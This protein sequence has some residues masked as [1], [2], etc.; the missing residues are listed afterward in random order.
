[1]IYISVLLKVL[2]L[3]LLSFTTNV[4][5]GYSP[6][7]VSCPSNKTLV[8]QG[9]GLSHDEK[10]WLAK[11]HSITTP[12]LKAFLQ[13]KTNLTAAEINGVFQNNSSDINVG[14][15][16]SG[17]GYRA[18]LTGAGELSAL[19]N[20]TV[21]AFEHGLGGLLESTTYISGLSGGNWLTGSLS[22][23]DWISVQ[24]IIDNKYDIW[25]LEN[26]IFLP[27]G[28]HP[29]KTYEVFRNI[30]LDVEAKK[31]AG[32]N[33][34]LTDV[35]ARSLARGFFESSGDYGADVCWSSLRDKSVFVNGEMPFPI[36][37]SDGRYPG[38]KLVSSNSTNFEFNAFEMGSWDP[39]V[40][41]FVDTKYLGTELDNGVVKGDNSQCV[42]GYDN[43]GFI[44]GTS[45]TLF[46]LMVAK[47]E[48]TEI[49]LIK[50]LKMKFV[51]FIKNLSSDN[52]DISIISPN[53]FFNT[54]YYNTSS[55]ISQSDSLFLVDGGED[56]QN[57]PFTPLIQP[58][59]E[60]DIIMAFD[61]GN[62]LNGLPDGT[63]MAATYDRQF[64]DV[65]VLGTF[66]YVP[67][68][69]TFLANGLT[70]KPTF[71]GC[72]ASNLTS[73]VGSDDH[74]HVPPLVVYVANRPYS[75]WSNTSTTK[76]S[77]TEQEKLAMITN[78][79][80]IASR[81]NL[82]SDAAAADWATCV[83]CAVI[84]RS[85]ERQGVAQSDTCQK[86][87]SEYCWNGK[88]ANTTISASQLME[89]LGSPAT[90]TQK[91]EGSKVKSL[92]QGIAKKIFPNLSTGMG[93]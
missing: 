1:M 59:R 19:D 65:G 63:A 53:P 79:F 15:A 2:I 73:L 45:S 51:N 7:H 50:S 43:A 52:D 40:D 54:H 46:N 27:E 36:T 91:K 29:I 37:V 24:D 66:P 78:G 57:I 48:N 60:V 70:S 41:A 11:R 31:N 87:F 25:D 12:N 56:G 62:N 58:A 35:W 4:L 76:M 8:R 90:T 49:H 89:T 26:S 81:N 84:R 23:N 83:G 28:L 3:S 18:M 74:G 6:T 67:D 55:S 39:T 34:S 22:M 80:E 21:G 13:T 38:T 42:Q 32:F 44:M 47:L 14:I 92:L 85:Q 75:Y 86:C 33:T 69:A 16:L 93:V 10:T 9:T 77:Y 82:T 20:R 71:F 88:T 68:Q 17:G 61:N 72:D 5:G 30:S 64:S